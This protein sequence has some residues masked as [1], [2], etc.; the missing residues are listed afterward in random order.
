[1]ERQC[2]PTRSAGPFLGQ[3]AEHDEIDELI[4]KGLLLAKC[5]LLGETKLSG[6]GRA[7]VVADRAA[8]DHAVKRQL[9]EG[10]IY[11]KTTGA[12]DQTPALKISGD[13]VTDFNAAVEPVDG[14]IAHHA[15]KLPSVKQRCLEAFVISKL[16]KSALDKGFVV[17]NGRS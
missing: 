4:V 17:I 12:N 2:D 9:V 8:N 7:A 14:V 6:N 13:P 5:T 16:L 1:M 3:H 10:V 15:D 11:Q